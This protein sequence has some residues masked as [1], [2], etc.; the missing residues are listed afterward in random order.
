MAL[1]S[2]SAT[3]LLPPARVTATDN[4]AIR[5]LIITSSV[6]HCWLA[7]GCLWLATDRCTALTTTMWMVTRVHNRATDCWAATHM[8]G[9]SG[10]TNAAVL[11]I[12]VAYLADGRHTQNVYAALLARRET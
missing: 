10:L 4:E 6:T 9:T 5:S 8:T 12:N 1:F 11:V 7:P 3:L 2:L